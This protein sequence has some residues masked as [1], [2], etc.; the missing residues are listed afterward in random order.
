MESAAIKS[1]VIGDLHDPNGET[2]TPGPFGQ[3]KVELT[4]KS[5]QPIG[6]KEVQDIFC[7]CPGGATA[8]FLPAT[9]PYKPNRFADLDIQSPCGG[10][11]GH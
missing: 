7:N 9:L 6:I 8:E 11:G 5:F 10:G 3:L 2:V 4:S 1:D